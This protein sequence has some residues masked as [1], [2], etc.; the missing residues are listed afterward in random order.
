MEPYHYIG[1]ECNLGI[2]GEGAKNFA[3]GGMTGKASDGIA[4]R[5][6]FS[7]TLEVEVEDIFPGTLTRRA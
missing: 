7:V 4:Y 3:E 5:G 2:F 6:V 1:H